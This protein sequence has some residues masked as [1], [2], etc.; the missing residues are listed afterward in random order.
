MLARR[1]VL[2]VLSLGLFFFVG[3]SAD[4]QTEPRNCRQELIFL[5]RIHSLERISAPLGPP[6]CQFKIDII[7][8]PIPDPDCP[9]SAREANLLTFADSK[10]LRRDG[11]VIRGIMM[12]FDKRSW[13][14]TLD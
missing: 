12:V 2:M 8:Q 14:E 10:C 5:G 1:V 6:I 3:R 13:I 11:E 7:E 9:L 4:A